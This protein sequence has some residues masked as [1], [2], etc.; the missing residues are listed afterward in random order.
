MWLSRDPTL[1]E[2][3]R[4]EPAGPIIGSAKYAAVRH[5]SFQGGEAPRHSRGKVVTPVVTPV[6]SPLI[7]PP[8]WGEPESPAR[9][10]P[11]H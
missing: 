8:S 10:P 11:P 6:L 1:G 2:G 3:N 5:P 7:P 4:V 9:S